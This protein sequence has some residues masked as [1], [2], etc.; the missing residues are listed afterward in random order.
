MVNNNKK[1]TKTLIVPDIHLRHE[2]A[3][4]IIASEKPDKIIF[5]GDYWD[6]FGDDLQ[7]VQE[8]SEWF[9]WS[10]NQSNRIHICGNHC[11]HYWFKDNP[12]VRCSGYTQWKSTAINDIVKKQDFEKLVFYYNLDDKWLLSHAG[13][14]P[15]WLTDKRTEP[16]KTNIKKVSKILDGQ[17][18]AFLTATG[19]GKWHWFDVPGYSRC[20][21]SPYYG[22]ILWLDWNKEFWPIKGLNQLVGHTPNYKLSWK[23]LTEGDAVTHDAPLGVVPK[24]SDQAS[25]NLC[26]DSQPGS[27]YYAIYE[28]GEKSLLTIHETKD[29]K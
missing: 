23:F 29:I 6:D 20:N 13:V 18:E 25:Y 24:F 8:T 3:E 14:H 26:L 4:R 16:F 19:R 21:G 2:I 15:H 17:S 11:L 27:Q 5:L 28:D 10:V 1:P 9:S 12:T 7:M 22:G